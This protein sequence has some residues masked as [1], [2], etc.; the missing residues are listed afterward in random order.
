MLGA[1]AIGAVAGLIFSLLLAIASV[2]LKADQTIGGTAL[3]LFAP[4]FAIVLTWAIQG[5]GQTTI[6]IPTWIKITA[7]HWGSAQSRSGL[8]GCTSFQEHLPDHSYCLGNPGPDCLCH[9]QDS[10]WPA[11]EGLWRTSPC[12]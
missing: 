3:N 9:L 2:S 10:L 12:S 7:K 6:N 8:L 5:Q 4:A 11:P 1:M